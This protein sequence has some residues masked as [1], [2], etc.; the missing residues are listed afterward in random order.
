VTTPICTA[1]ARKLGIMKTAI[2]GGGC[3]A[4]SSNLTYSLAYN[5]NANTTEVHNVILTDDLPGQTDFVSASAGASYDQNTHRVTWNLGS[6]AAGGSGTQQVTIKVSVAQG[7]T[8]TNACTVTSDETGASQVSR[9]VTVCGQSRRN[10]ALK[11]ATH[12]KAHP[13]SCTKSY[14][15]FISCGQIK[16]TYAEIGDI[17]VLPVF[18]DLNEYALTE[19]AL[20]WPTEW[21][22]ASFVRCKG[23]IAVGSITQPGE[24]IAI[25]WSACQY[26]WAVAPGFAWLGATSPGEIRIVPNPATGDFGVVNCAPSPGPYYDYPMGVG[27]SGVG[28]VLGNDPCWPTRIEPSTWGAIKAMFK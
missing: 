20:V 16:T 22:N 8:F 24:G 4:Y 7:V 10:P 2:P 6:L 3:V 26:G 5:N 19:F 15:T 14:P 27:K 21:G 18:Y 13:T 17:D 12:V 9:A 23:D 1:Q 28:G 25:A 11:I